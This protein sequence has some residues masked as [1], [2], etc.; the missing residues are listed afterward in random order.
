MAGARRTDIVAAMPRLHRP[1][2]TCRLTQLKRTFPAQFLKRRIL[3]RDGPMLPR[4]TVVVPFHN[5]A[6][7]LERCVESLLQQTHPYV[8]IILVDDGSTDG[9]AEA[10][11]RLARDFR[12]TLIRQEHLGT[13][14]ARNAGVRAARGRHLA[15]CDSDDVVLTQGY[16]RLATALVTS[17]SDLAVGSVTLQDRGRHLEPAWARRSNA[18]RLVGVTLDDH[19]EV[20][21]NLMPGP[22]VFRRDFWLRQELEFPT[23][24][25]ESGGYDDSVPM[26]RAMLLAK[27]IDILPA[28][29]YRWRWREDGTSLLQR[30][31]LDKTLMADR[32]AAVSAAGDLVAESASEPVQR[33]FFAE[34]LHTTVPRLVRSAITRHDGYWERLGTELHHFLDL[35]SPETFAAVPV[36]DR[37]IAWLCARGHRD[38]AESFLEYAFDNQN[39]YPYRIADDWPYITLPFIDAL[40]EA[41]DELTAASPVELRY[42]TRLLSAGWVEPHVLRVRGAAFME[43]LDDSY[44]DSTVVLVLRDRESGRTWRVETEHAPGTVINGWSSRAQEDHDRGAFTCDID[45]TTLPRPDRHPLVLD[46]DVELTI[47]THERVDGFGSRAYHDSAGLLEPSAF[48]GLRVR[49]AWRPFGGLVLDLR[50][51]NANA[52]PVSELP[53]HAEVLVTEVRAEDRHVV[54]TVVTERPEPIEISLVGPRGSTG[55]HKPDGAG[56]ELT[57]RL[58]AFEDEWG[59]GETPLPA[60]RYAV[61]ARTAT[62]EELPVSPARSLWRRLPQPVE[63]FGLR[64]VPEAGMEGQMQ[65][66]VLP[67]EWQTSR[68]PFYSRRLRDVEYPESRRQPLLEVALFE[69]FGGKAAGDNPGALCAELA[70]RGGPELVVSVIDRSIPVPDGARAV[71]RFSR[72]Y[73]ELLGRARYLIVNASLPYFFR[74]REGQLYFQ[75]WHGTPLKRIAHDRPH[76]DFNNWHHRRQLLIARDGWDYLLS[77]SEFCTRSLTSAF[78]YDGPVLEVGYPRNDVLSSPDADELRRRTRAHFGIGDDQQLVLYAPTWRDNFRVGRTF[79]KV[80]YLDPHQL[81]AELGGDAVVLV[82]GHYN[83]IRAAEDVD[84]AH[85]VIDVTR[86]PDIGDLYL[87]ADALVTDYSSVFFDFVLTDKPM[88]FLAPDLKEYRDDNRGFYLDY[89]VVPGPVCLTTTEVARALRG[90]DQHAQR[91]EEFRAEFTPYDDGGA[92]ARVIDTI[93][94]WPGVSS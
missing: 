71:I 93:L 83:S 45:F 11:Q 55:W 60:D 35:L 41:S 48:D 81:V 42:R 72:E 23:D 57:V 58:D 75:T 53:E 22:R 19:P 92:A 44:A 77:Q 94:G 76:L 14:A 51:P 15:F 66:R 10:A 79:D 50:V 54:L 33:A 49:V 88:V 56:P 4:L 16:E 68:P 89:D 28:V 61:H 12:V 90:P 67:A 18:H 46:V 40:A 30:G 78:R 82:R 87:A 8:R 85:R 5:T 34:I 91:R 7:R 62:G 52:I 63:A 69:T 29:V 64:F 6:G 39:G 3:R 37:V 73:Y 20:M 43:Y 80:L 1:G 2:S 21:A 70:R 36:E 86:Y 17:G 59:L 31:L 84:P 47:G 74:K 26:V 65:I 27:R 32:M 25:G 24:G 13:G 38:A 9:S